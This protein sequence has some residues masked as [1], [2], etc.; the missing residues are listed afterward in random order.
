MAV[1]EIIGSYRHY[2]LILGT[3]DDGS[4]WC[5]VYIRVKGKEH[6]SSLTF[7]EWN[8]GIE[9]DG[10]IVDINVRDQQGIRNWAEARG[11]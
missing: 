8:G 2:G 4:T 3:E 11:Y 1:K 7:I 10:K 6:C 5:H 9:V